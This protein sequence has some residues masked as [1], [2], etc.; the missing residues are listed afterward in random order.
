[1]HFLLQFILWFVVILAVPLLLIMTVALPWTLRSYDFAAMPTF[2]ATRLKAGDIVLLRGR[3]VNAGKVL[4]FFTHIMLC[5]EKDGQV[6]TTEAT[7]VQ[8][9]DVNGTYHCIPTR[10]PKDSIAVYEGDYCVRRLRTP[11]SSEQVAALREAVMS[12]QNDTY[13]WFIVFSYW[14]GLTPFA[15][16]VSHDRRYYCS[17]YVTSLLNCILPCRIPHPLLKSPATYGSKYKSTLDV[18]QLTTMRPAIEDLYSS[19]SVPI[20]T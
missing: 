5:Y 19:E 7:P 20:F 3:G 9:L 12:R 15:S 17:E 1:M 18:L 14:L 11:L 13:D 10:L 16:A 6:Y 8:Q 2:D 4:G